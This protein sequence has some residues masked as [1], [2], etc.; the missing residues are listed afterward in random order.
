V[1]APSASKAALHGT[2]HHPSPMEESRPSSTESSRSRSGTETE[3]PPWLEILWS[4]CAT[5]SRHEICICPSRSPGATARGPCARVT[6]YHQA[7]SAVCKSFAERTRS[8]K[9]Y[10]VY[11][12]NRRAINV[13][14]GLLRFGPCPSNLPSYARSVYEH[15]AC[16]EA[17]TE[18][19]A[20][21]DRSIALKISDGEVR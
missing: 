20:P 3:Y 1:L 9:R 15:T 18:C 7:S 19:V 14:V 16:M 21:Q 4:L 12:R 6:A 8:W 17:K 11:E 10:M 5:L 2:T 13:T